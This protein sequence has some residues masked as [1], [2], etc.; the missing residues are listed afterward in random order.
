[1]DL[2]IIIVNYNSKSKLINCL[3]SIFN[4]GLEG[5][6][7]EVAVVDNNSQDDLSDLNLKFSEVQIISS[8]NNLGM[9]GGN[10]LGIRNTSS[11]FILILNPDT[12]IKN[13]AIPLMLDYL[14]KNPKVGMIGPKL[15]YP[16]GSLQY[17]CSRFPHFFT[18]ILR[19]T[20]L[21]EYFKESRDRF[22]MNDFDH[23]SIREVDWL[24]GSCM[25]FRRK[26]ILGDGQIFEPLFDERYF[27]YFEDID[28]SRQ[29]WSKGFSIIYNPE[30]AVIHDHARESARY[31]WYLAILLDGLARRHIA[32]WLN[33]F[34]KWGI[35][36][37]K[38]N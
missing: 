28:L 4:S 6:K 25:M 1:M 38:N 10:N 23:N 14:K 32:S 21:G 18:P 36:K 27:M 20:F 15:L 12:L 19:R 24:M 35:R 9:G 2:S 34:L 3:E 31:P 8:T 33:Y 30:A 5:I 17:S 26:M 22:T 11:E 13:G 29:I 7:Y 16:D 37:E